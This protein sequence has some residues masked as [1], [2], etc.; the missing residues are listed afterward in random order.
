MSSAEDGMTLPGIAPS[1]S[2][3]VAYTA[4]TAYVENG[5][6][7]RLRRKRKTGCYR[8]LHENMASPRT[9]NDYTTKKTMI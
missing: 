1:P 6:A 5:M 2:A 8:V 9:C 4:Y 7:M 3:Y